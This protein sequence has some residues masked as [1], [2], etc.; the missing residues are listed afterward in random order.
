M[1][2]ALL[3]VF[4]LARSAVSPIVMAAVSL[5]RRR[6]P[7]RRREPQQSRLSPE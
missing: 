3:S 5:R 7:S 6:R 1:S 4:A 2:A